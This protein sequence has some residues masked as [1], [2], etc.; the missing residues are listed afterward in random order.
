MKAQDIL[1]D[2][3]DEEKGAYLGAI[4]SIATADR[5]AGEEEIEFLRTLAKE[6]NLS[7]EQEEAVVRAA[8]EI[9]DTELNR[10]LDIL[11]TSDLRFSL[12][13]D[14]ISFANAD[15]KY[16]PEEK[17]DVEKIAAYLRVNSEQFSL[18][19][20]FV[21]KSS[22]QI[23]DPQSIT[24]PGFFESLGFKDK[25]QKA[26]IN[27]GGITK[28]LLSM[29]GPMLLGSL[30]S[31]GMGKRPGILNSGRPG[32]GSPMGGLGS[33]LSLLSGGRGYPGMRNMTPGLFGR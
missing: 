2:Y 26:G 1:K 16:S 19:D 14:I 24:Q 6:S 23:P 27:T 22:E 4:A 11:K 3:S 29:L 12:I 8:R 10:C 13:T 33:L 20:Q 5:E 30:L 15:G 32:M 9:S 28:G 17:A 7:R 31:R 21:K 25:F 18:L